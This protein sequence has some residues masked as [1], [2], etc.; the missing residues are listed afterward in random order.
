MTSRTVLS[1]LRIPE[2]DY[3]PFEELPDSLPR[4]TAQEYW[5]HIQDGTYLLAPR[6]ALGG[7]GLFLHGGTSADDVAASLLVAIVT[8]PEGKVRQGSREPWDHYAVPWNRFA[9]DRRAQVWAASSVVAIAKEFED[10]DSRAQFRALTPMLP[11]PYPC[12]LILG[13]LRIDKIPTNEWG[14]NELQELIRERR[15]HGYLTVVTSRMTVAELGVTY[16]P[17][18][19]ELFQDR[20]VVQKGG[21]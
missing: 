14:V 12:P 20:F 1:Q 6:S 16:G 21:L 3:R 11:S 7:Y 10:P 13:L 8:D 2:G 17:E 5:D 4:R 18:M 15:R 9:V 19:Q